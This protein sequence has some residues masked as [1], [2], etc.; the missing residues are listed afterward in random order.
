MYFV[1]YFKDNVYSEEWKKVTNE[2]TYSK[3]LKSVAFLAF[4]NIYS[5]RGI[6]SEAYVTF[7]PSNFHIQHYLKYFKEE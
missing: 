6:D 4:T 1:T 3:T 2:K 7:L 5:F